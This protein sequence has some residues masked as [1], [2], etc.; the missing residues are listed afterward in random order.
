MTMQPINAQ[1]KARHSHAC[2]SEHARLSPTQR[3]CGCTMSTIR[4]KQYIIH[5]T[6]TE[7]KGE[8]RK[9]N[10]GSESSRSSLMRSGC[11]G[12]TGD[13][14]LTQKL[15]PNTNNP[16]P[17]SVCASWAI[18]IHTSCLMCHIKIVY[19]CTIP[20]SRREP[21]VHTVTYRNG[22]LN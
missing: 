8:G 7:N 19:S 11:S 2:E 17:V 20:P 9:P 16:L 21:L 1:P 3:A 14:A 5:C 15:R 22:A 18:G 6:P 4:Y 10:R 13:D 12:Q